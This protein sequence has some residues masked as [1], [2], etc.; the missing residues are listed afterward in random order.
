LNVIGVV[1]HNRGERQKG[2]IGVN[3]WRLFLNNIKALI[4]LWCKNMKTYQ[5]KI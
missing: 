5:C 2:T 3:R 1:S 4:S